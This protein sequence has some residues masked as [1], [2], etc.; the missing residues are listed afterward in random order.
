M[1]VILALLLPSLPGII[2]I[3][4]KLFGKGGGSDKAKA[5]LTQILAVINDLIA[6]GKIAKGATIDQTEIQKKI[7]DVVKM[8]NSAGL[9]NGADTDIAAVIKALEPLLGEKSPTPTPASPTTSGDLAG[10]ILRVVVLK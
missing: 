2:G 3:I 8:L 10:T 7:E 4:E 1:G 6:S 5:V 9:L